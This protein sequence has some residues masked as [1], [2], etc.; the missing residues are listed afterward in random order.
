M[1]GTETKKNRTG[2][3]KEQALIQKHWQSTRR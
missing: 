1:K 3:P 2:K